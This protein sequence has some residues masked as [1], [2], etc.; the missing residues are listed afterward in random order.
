MK[1]FSRK[2]ILAAICLI[3][4]V[5]W[6]GFSSRMKARILVSLPGGIKDY[7]VSSQG[8]VA[9]TGGSSAAESQRVIVLINDSGSVN[10]VDTT[11]ANGSIEWVNFSPDGRK[12]VG[13]TYGG[14]WIAEIEHDNITK[15]TSTGPRATGN[16][17]DLR[18]ISRPALFNAGLVWCISPPNKKS[19]TLL[20]SRWKIDNADFSDRKYIRMSQPTAFRRVQFLLSPNGEKAAT[21][22]EHIGAGGVTTVHGPNQGLIEIWDMVQDK[23]ICELEKIQPKGLSP[24]V[25]SPDAKYVAAGDST[26]TGYIWNA[27]H[28]QLVQTISGLH[29]REK[30][31]GR[32]YNMGYGN[33][34]FYPPINLTFTPDNRR[35]I[36]ALNDGYIIAYDFE[37]GLPLHILTKR[38]K[39]I[40]RLT[41]SPDNRK[42]YFV[43]DE[44][45]S[46]MDKYKRQTLY[47]IPLPEFSK[48][49]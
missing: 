25:F 29:H 16:S 42:L 22:W 1:M 26:G 32:R 5:T 18:D 30:G 9:V 43:E 14:L 38:D 21:V 46:Q 2:V 10:R 7:A 28:G 45:L 6:W 27:Q 34:S 13:N 12:L 20:A 39:P 15:E 24:L 23:K 8:L 44:T 35:L 11:S 48:A 33:L 40:G 31:Q 36:A 49:P 47:S 3:L 17:W 19:S 4:L 41:V 37:S